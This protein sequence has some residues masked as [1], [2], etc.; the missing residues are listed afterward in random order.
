MVAKLSVSQELGHERE[1]PS[2]PVEVSFQGAQYVTNCSFT[3]TILYFHY[4]TMK[5]ENKRFSL[6]FRPLL[7]LLRLSKMPEKFGAEFEGYKK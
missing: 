3:K 7:L 2:L 5:Y 1:A 4:L 6:L